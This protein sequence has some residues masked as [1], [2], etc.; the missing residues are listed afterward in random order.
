MPTVFAQGLK[1]PIVYNTGAYDLFE[2][3]RKPAG[4]VDIYL[5]DFKYIKNDTAQRLSTSAQEA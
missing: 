5:P 4:I 3:T 2:T 1:I